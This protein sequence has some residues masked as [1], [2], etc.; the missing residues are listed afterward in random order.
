[1]VATDRRDDDNNDGHKVT[2]LT[3]Y[4]FTMTEMV[5]KP[6]TLCSNIKEFIEYW[7]QHILTKYLPKLN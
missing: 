5:Y 7:V 6:R 2:K 1:M 4:L 3:T